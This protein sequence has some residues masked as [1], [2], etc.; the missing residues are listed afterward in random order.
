MPNLGVA[1]QEFELWVGSNMGSSDLEF[2]LET[3]S[4]RGLADPE[5]AYYSSLGLDPNW[6]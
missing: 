1:D 2:G 6:V 5:S 4:V 3:G